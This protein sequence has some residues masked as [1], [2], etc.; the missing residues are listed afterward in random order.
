LSIFY[1]LSNLNWIAV[2]LS[3][4][5][6]ILMEVFW[7]YPYLVWLGQWQAIGWQRTPL[8]LAS[9][10]FLLGASFLVTRFFLN[11]KWSLLWVQLAVIFCG[12]AAIFAVVRVEYGAGFEPLDGQWFA[13]A[14][15]IFANSF[16]QLHPMV[17]ACVTAVYIWWRGIVHGR[18]PLYSA[19]IYRS[20]L[21]GIAALVI[22]V[23]VWR[24]SPGTVSFGN[25]T[26]AVG[27]Y[28]AAF[29]FFGLVALAL[30]NL[31]AIQLRMLTE[32]TARTF[33]RRWLPILFGVVG[34]IVLVGV[35]IA[36]ALSPEFLALVARLFNSAGDILSQGLRYL[37][38]PL[39]YIAAGFFYAMQFIANWLTG[40]K[41]MEPFAIADFAPTQKPTEIASSGTF[42]TAAVLVIKW[43]L[44]AAIVIAIIILLARAISRRR[45]ERAKAG[46]EE[47]HESL[48][49]WGGF[50]A[51][52]NQFF[53]MIWGWF[54]R[55]G[56]KTV[57]V[58]PAPRWHPEPDIPGGTLDIREIYRHLLWEASRSRTAR[59][60][61]E[62]PYEYATRLGQAVPDGSRQLDKL[63]DLYIDTRY[64]DREPGD[65]QVNYAN[66]LWRALRSL[67]RKPGGDQSV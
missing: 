6:V 12:L 4:I 45:S 38:I 26:S 28:I 20:F 23:I 56:R 53:S 32:E 62:T 46:V 44:F 19:N 50:M 27:P 66:S 54:T 17:I 48:W 39:E 15:Q 9:L 36:S 67:L 57:T 58:S 2:A 5:A 21:I 16:S 1:R 22:L 49:S 43:C 60:L 41:P 11:R 35:G 30:T 52:L 61:H 8:S 3:R 51:D 40:G 64:G 25:L 55:K 37:F 59:R 63:T 24:A 29:F 7:V 42:P 65:K 33:N 18:T 13:Y 34:G 31:Q 14:G 10:I 47:I